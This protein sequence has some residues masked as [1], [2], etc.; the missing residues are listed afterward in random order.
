MAKLVVSF[1]GVVEGHYF[2]DKERFT[3][4]RKSDSDIFLDGPG[5][6]NIHAV[7]VTISNDHVLE[8]ATSTNGILVNGKKVAKHILQ[9]NDVIEL[10]AYQ[11]KYIN[12]RATSD[13]DFDKTM[14]MKAVQP[15]ADELPEPGTLQARPQ[16]ATAVFSA[17]SVKTGFPLGGVKN[18][19]GPQ[20]GEEILISRP[21]K[22]F[23]QPGMQV[24]MISRR[25]HG[26]YVTHV[27]GK[28]HPR[29]NGKS[30]G[31]QP[32]LLQ[33]NDLIEAGDVKLKFFMQ[34]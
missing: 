28:K 14:I 34:H 11:L 27:E 7:I 22:T 33:E 13:M 31:T 6:S 19:K 20:P 32:W 5:V 3:I 23:G 18:M 25:P 1:E 17:R 4:G 30:I 16:L 21:L 26:Y 10:S 24:V 29:V 12:Q 9:N 2:L 8:D 15:E